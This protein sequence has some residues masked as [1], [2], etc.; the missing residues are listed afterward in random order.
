MNASPPRSFIARI[1]ARARKPNRE[2]MQ[3][4]RGRMPF[5]WVFLVLFAFATW[6]ISM[7]PFGFSDLTQRYTQDISELLITG[8]YLYPTTGHEQISVALI[9]E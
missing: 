1:V 7:N 8:P 4:L 9:E 2:H 5:W 3:V 6:Q